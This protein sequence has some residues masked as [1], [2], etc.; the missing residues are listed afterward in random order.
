MKHL[1]AVF[2]T[3]VFAN[4]LFAEFNKADK[5]Q[6]QEKLLQMEALFNKGLSA[7]SR[8][9]Y[10][11]GEHIFRSLTVEFPQSPKADESRY[12]LALCCLKLFR[13]REAGELLDTLLERYKTGTEAERFRALREEVNR[14][15]EE[16]SFTLDLLPDE[17]RPDPLDESL[18]LIRAGRC[19]NAIL[20]LLESAATRPGYMQYFYLGLA[21]EKKHDT[22]HPN[23]L[24]DYLSLSREAYE[25]ALTFKEGLEA[26]HNLARLCLKTGDSARSQALY[27][28][29]LLKYPDSDLAAKIKADLQ[30][31][32]GKPLDFNEP[33]LEK[34]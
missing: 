10:T 4:I 5:I 29:I 9:D 16:L 31:S 30:G 33:S 20:L 1:L 26:M 32:G 17:E 25:K 24:V 27:E 19:D 13:I 12:Y 15:S 2:L 23:C 3:L 8:Q 28:K 34:E 11:E 14:L 21:Y 22:M 6:E 18:R 7:F